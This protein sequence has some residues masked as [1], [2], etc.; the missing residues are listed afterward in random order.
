M[1]T[2][3]QITSSR[4]IALG[5]GAVKVDYF[6]DGEFVRSEVYASRADASIASLLVLFPGTSRTWLERMHG[7]TR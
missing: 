7:V 1:T 2:K 4:S 6:A 5:N 3:E